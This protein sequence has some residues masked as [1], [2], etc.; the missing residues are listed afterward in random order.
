MSVVSESEELVV[1]VTSDGEDPSRNVV[2]RNKTVYSWKV[3][4][5]T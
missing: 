3:G 4:K 5:R 1:F 2:E